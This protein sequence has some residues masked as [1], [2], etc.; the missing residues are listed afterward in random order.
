METCAFLGSA[1]LAKD[2]QGAEE[3]MER[4]QELK[5]EIDNRDEK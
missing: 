2:V 5:V 4:H 3:M 1:E